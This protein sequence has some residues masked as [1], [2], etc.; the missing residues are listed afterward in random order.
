MLDGFIVAF[1]LCLT[2]ALGIYVAKQVK[3][4]EEYKTGGRNYPAWIILATLT[5]SFIGGGFTIGLAEKTFSYGILF[6]LAMWGF[7][8]KE[9][10]IAKLIAPRMHAF[11]DATTVGDIMEISYGPKTKIFTG[12]A[13][14]L[15]CGGIIG[16]QVA[17]CG[18]ILYIFLGL[19]K[20]YGSL[21]TAGIVVIYASYGGMKSVVTVDVLHFAILIVMLPLA[22]FF[23][24]QA[25]GGLDTVLTHV[26]PNYLD[27]TSQL[28]WATLLVL[29]LSFFFGETLIPPYIQRLLIGKTTEATE[30]G[31][32]W[33]GLISFPFFLIIGCI[34]MVAFVLSP[35]LMPSTALPFVIEN[36]MP[37]GL[38]GLAIAAMLAVVMSSADSFL[39]STATALSGDV[40]K[41]LNLTGKTVNNELWISRVV[42]LVIGVVAIVFALSVPSVL[43][44]L[45]YS[46]QFWT[47]FI[48]VPLVAAIFGVRSSDKVFLI[49]AAVGIITLVGWNTL[50]AGAMID[51]ALEGVI[52]GI[53]TNAICFFICQKIFAT[54]LVKAEQPE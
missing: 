9:V 10:L 37:I 27:P 31:T 33:S 45:L 1:Y 43:D 50:S 15:V 30:K 11:H 28:G 38:K 4:P 13:S 35:T 14:L 21:I 47:P 49:S 51:G 25:V 44:I 39:N 19:P 29:F 36:T 46:Y 40:L 52:L 5:A 24:L 7:S 22:L 48:L 26:P 12:V 41:P 53:F 8:V 23:G 54:P 2:L 32:L 3:S 17:A 6:I 20:I 42:T 16:A 18:N 34:G